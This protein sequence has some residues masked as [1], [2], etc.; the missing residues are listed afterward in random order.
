MEKINKDGFPAIT[1]ESIKITISNVNRVSSCVVTPISPWWNHISKLNVGE[2]FA[3]SN[4]ENGVKVIY[5]IKRISVDKGLLSYEPHY[6]V[7][8]IPIPDNY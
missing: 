3:F 6:G 5:S 2:E 8:D 4:H 7:G 1:P